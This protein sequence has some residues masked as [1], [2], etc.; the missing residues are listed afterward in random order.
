MTRNSQTI[1]IIG[2]CKKRGVCCHRIVVQFPDWARFRPF[3]WG[4]QFWYFLLYNFSMHTWESA[5]GQGVFRCHFLKHNLCSIYKWRPRICR[6]Y[7]HR[8]LSGRPQLL[9]GCGYAGLGSVQDSNNQAD[10]HS[11]G[12]GA[13]RNKH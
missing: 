13:N 2:G 10:H 5:N 12:E 11:S 9:P 3:R 6:D 4:V 1:P 7:P 8:T